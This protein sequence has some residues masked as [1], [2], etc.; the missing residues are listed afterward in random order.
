MSSVD[1]LLQ[2]ASSVLTV[3]TGQR[4]GLVDAVV[5]ESENTVIRARVSPSHDDLPATVIV[6]HVTDVEFDQPGHSGP[7]SRFLNEWATL[8]FLTGID[9]SIAPKLIA[10]DLGHGL[11]IVEDLGELP[12]LESLLSGRDSALVRDGL[13]TVGR[14]LGRLHATSR[15]RHGHFTSI[16]ARL[17]TR[18]PMSDSTIDQRERRV[19]FFSILASMEIGPG[20]GFWD[21]IVTMETLVLED[22]PFRSLIH[23]DAGP[24][25]VLISANGSRLI[26]FEFA[27]YGN[28]L[29][30]AVGARLGFPQTMGVG[31]VPT[32]SVERLEHAYRESL[33]AGI[34]EA[35]DDALFRRH[36]TAACGHWAL[37]R[38]T[39]A[40]RDHLSG[41]L[42]THRPSDSAVKATE[43]VWLVI[44]GFVAAARE[45]GE[46]QVV[47]DALRRFR[48]AATQRWPE[49]GAGSVYPALRNL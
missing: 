46:F 19:E 35:E 13:E 15:S 25:N 27:T 5:L 40:W 29:C 39:Y 42:D 34:P 36:M 14:L 47:G 21:E 33:L 28:S 32:R 11:S 22:S 44:D 43:G 41:V 26:D 49:L 24:H 9:D 20:K 4:V 30:D 2:A 12:T 8:E 48:E 23:A 38:W 17:G 10:A 1:S 37:N 6:K 31:Q 45:F 16:Q 7:P 18:S 3:A